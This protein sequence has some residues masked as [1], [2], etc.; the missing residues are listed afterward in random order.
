MSFQPVK[1]Y[2]TG[3]YTVGNRLLTSEGIAEN[4]LHDK[5]IVSAKF[6]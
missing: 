6:G 2:Q 3:T 1:F 5:G 4:I